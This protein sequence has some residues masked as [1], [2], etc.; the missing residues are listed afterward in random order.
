MATIRLVGDP[1]RGP[2]RLVVAAPWDVALG[3]VALLRHRRSVYG[4]PLPC[5]PGHS[6]GQEGGGFDDA[7]RAASFDRARPDAP[8]DRRLFSAEDADSPGS[9]SDLVLP[10]PDRVD[11]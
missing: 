5:D 9:F 11:L 4:C 10:S 8:L 2:L 1:L 3:A 6:R 7:I